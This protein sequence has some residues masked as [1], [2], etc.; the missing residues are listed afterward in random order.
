M[1]EQSNNIADALQSMINARLLDVNTS[2]P[3]VILSYKNGLARVQ[4]VGK[5]RFADGDELEYPVIPNARV[6]WPSFSGGSA[7]FKAPVRAGDRCLLVFAQ[8]GV[9]GTDDKRMFDMSD[10][11]AVMVD[12]GN[13]GA[14][15][16][17]NN[18]DCTMF[19][20][21]AYIRLTEAGKLIIN[22]PAGTE[23]NT[24]DYTLNAP[25]NTT[26]NTP[27]TTNNGQLTTTGL[28]TYASGM[29][30]GG[31]SGTYLNGSVNINGYVLHTGD[32]SHT[33]GTMTSLG[34]KIDGTHTHGGVTA[35][36]AN[37]NTPNP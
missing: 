8:A 3:A 7:G 22:A 5:K 20:G 2:L 6:C 35:G 9:D 16:S 26:I 19:F 24:A 15:D 13:A 23:I 12:L 14:G 1:A 33:G 18:N 32:Y 34:K 4:P 17:G 21:S 29:T 36:G 37:T 27:L 31:G 10:C 28:L 30:G 11:Y 25:N